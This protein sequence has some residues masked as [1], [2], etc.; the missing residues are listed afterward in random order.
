M[1]ILIVGAGIG[2]LT[3]AGFLKDSSIEYDIIEKAP[4]FKGQGYSLGIW[5]NGRRI[6]EKL[7]L[8][9]EFDKVG[10]R[11]NNYLFLDGKGNLLLKYDLSKFYSEYGMAYTN[12][13][14]TAL[15]D[16][17]LNL[18]GDKKVKFGCTVERIVQE[19]DKV[20]VKFTF[21]EAKVYDLVVGADGIHS[22]IRSKIFGGDFEKFDDWRVWYAWVGNSLKERN[23]VAGY[24][25]PGSLLGTFDLNDKTLVILSAPVKH[26]IWDDAVGRRNRLE[27]LFKNQKLV[28]LLDDLKDE[29]FTVGDFSHV[30]M[31]NL[32]KGN[33]VL[34]GDAAHGFE[35]HAGLGAS[36]A[37][38]D[39]Y[40]LAGEL[41]KVSSTYLLKDA[42]SNYQDVRKKRVAIAR[43]LTNGMRGWA[44]LKSKILRK[45]LNI[46]MRF[47]PLSYIMNK[48]HKLLREEI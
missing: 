37:M 11:I 41:M 9:E 18:V 42:L 17:L 8:A 13:S 10:C 28:G 14:R 32:V 24:I 23:T 6:L 22:E 25:E 20:Q 27:V 48:Y 33:V 47:L 40:V 4:A 45:F 35:P 21:G 3:L 1:K 15:H 2:G 34:M 46:N 44:F 12:I 16:M 39:G 7:G 26:S 38:E 31:K 5:H 29:D 36:M 30:K 19:S 43:S